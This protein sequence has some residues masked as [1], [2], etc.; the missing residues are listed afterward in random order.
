LV[1]LVTPVIDYKV[2]DYCLLPYPDHPKGCPN[3]GKSDRCP[4]IIG[5]FD[6]IYDLSQP[7]YAIVGEYDLKSHV[8]NLRLKHNNW[9]ERQLR[10]V[11]YWQKTA[12]KLLRE[13]VNDWLIYNPQFTPTQCPEAMGL[14]VI[15][16]LNT[17]N[18]KLQFPPIDIVH[19]VVICGILKNTI[20]KSVEIELF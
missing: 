17:V 5:Y 4:P 16:T 3:Y 6:E 11:L 8:D 18:V 13:E 1:V 20:N 9:S 19:L 7:I 14:N 12:R 15:K 2:R 10:C